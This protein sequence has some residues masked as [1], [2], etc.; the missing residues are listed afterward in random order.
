[1]DDS[2]YELS[3]AP[4]VAYFS[5]EVG[6]DPRMP[7]Y[8]GGLGVLAG[9]TLRAAADSSIPMAGMTL[10]H[11]KGYFRQRLDAKG[12]QREAPV[13]W[14]PESILQLMP[15]RVSVL[16]EG[17]QVQIQAWRYLVKGI[18]G[19]TLPVYFLDTGL[20]E[21]NPGDQALTDYLYGGDERYRLCQEMVLGI[22]GAAILGALG[23]TELRT[24]HMNEGHSAL[25]SLAL[26]KEQ[27]RGGNLDAVTDEDIEI[28]RKHCVFTTHTPVPAGHDVFS[29]D[30]AGR[31]L[32]ANL[33]G[34]LQK[35]SCCF[36]GALNMTYLALYFSHYI[37]GVAMR[38][39]EISRDMYPNYPVNSITNGVH[40][41][42]W[43]VKPFQDLYDRYLPEWRHDNRY[44]RYAI[45]IPTDEFRKAH[46]EVKRQL[47][48]A[49]KLRKGVDL[50]VDTLTLGFARRS[51]AYK[52][53]DLL[54]F[55]IERLKR[56]VQQAGSLQI[57]YSGKA[58]PRDE[59]GKALIRR[60][61][62]AA[63]R[64]AGSITVVYL[65]DYDMDLAKLLIAGVDL[66]LNTPQKPL[67]AS[68][69]SGMK[70]AL[71]G[72]PSLSVLDG[73]WVEGHWENVS[74]W[75]IGHE[76]DSD[77]LAESIS[78]YNKLESIILP[79][80][81]KKP[82]DYAAVMRSA[83]AINGSFFNAQRMIDQYLRNVYLPAQKREKPLALIWGNKPDISPSENNQSGRLSN[84]N[85]RG[86]FAKSAKSKQSAAE[87]T[88][89]NVPEDKV[90]WN[91]DGQVFRNLQDLAQGLKTMSD[92]TYS[93]HVIDS[94]NDF[95]R[96]TG[97]VIGD[98]ELS[99]DLEQSANRSEAAEKVAV[100]TRS[101]Y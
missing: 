83:I 32:D 21:N 7:T 64:L 89:I 68:G 84:A 71:N 12:N 1:M 81:Y 5:M 23:C 67:E 74:G 58:H 24:Y 87:K 44:L 16:I 14:N 27:V 41:P 72:V 61:F 92:E 29:L 77:S 100:Y 49:V 76:S 13:D 19:F 26:L 39:G 48:Q 60:V 15:P 88:M 52:R 85:Q 93:H 34:F 75:A 95:A 70:A 2:N 42:T 56:V 38:H 17:R 99:K 10:L 46:A 9:D 98:D 35:S 53:A 37:N 91:R 69:T 78:L 20:P 63:A 3:F 90:F 54:F 4:Q 57:I 33:F 59:G 45:S 22:G 31:I 94:R 28:V 43:T 25:L 96:W 62:E 36:Q 51:T 79:L 18:S 11:R 97:E 55:D 101:D 86:Q 73:W 8:S 80:F 6:I 50:D 66:W 40:A 30:L 82:D 65:E 47:I